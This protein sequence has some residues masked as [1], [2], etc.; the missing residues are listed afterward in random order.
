MKKFAILL[1]VIIV[2]TFNFSTAALESPITESLTTTET[3][4]ETTSESFGDWLWRVVSEN[5]L[6][7]FSAISVGISAILLFL[8]KRNLFPWVRAALSKA[9]EFVTG[10][11]EDFSKWQET[12]E[13]ELKEYKE[14]VQAQL[15]TQNEAL[16]KYASDLENALQN[17]TKLAGVIEKDDKL[18]I[19]C[20]KDQEEAL[21][22]IIQS[23]TLAQWKKDEAGAKHAAHVAAFADLQS[24]EEGE[25]E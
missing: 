14:Q 3:I 23:S 2:L 9:L 15:T 22:T 5:V 4:E 13:K 11:K 20:L 16:K 12:T 7:I 24:T 6:T 1:A 25:S 10:A 19:M 8:T 17:V 21:N 18:L